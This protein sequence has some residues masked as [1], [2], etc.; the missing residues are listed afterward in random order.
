MD[1]LLLETKEIL[2]EELKSKKVDILC[3]DCL[4]TSKEVDFHFLG[5]K[6]SSA[7]PITPKCKN[8]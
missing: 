1:D 8:H 3:N 2:P 4:K 5:F 6:E 7:V